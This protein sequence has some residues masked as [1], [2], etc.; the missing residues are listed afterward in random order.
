MKYDQFYNVSKKETKAIIEEIN[1]SDKKFVFSLFGSCQRLVKWLLDKEGISK[2]LIGIYMPYSR[3]AINDY[4][5]CNSS[6]YVNL[7]LTSKVSKNKFDDFS[8]PNSL[9][10]DLLSIAVSSSLKT[11][12]HKR[13]DDGS[14]ISTYNG[15]QSI[16]YHIE[17]IADEFSR[18]QQD[19]IISFS[20]LKI[21]QLNNSLNF[22][23]L[24]LDLDNVSLVSI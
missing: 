2:N 22:S 16:N 14:Y 11:K 5:Q 17:F 12:K 1:I 9:N 15:K 21:I 10:D 7:Q 24:D 3:K 20:V 8:L 6:S 19:F 4:T 18:T 23:S 13:S